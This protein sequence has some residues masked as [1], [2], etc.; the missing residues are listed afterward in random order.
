MQD[1]H[2]Y[3]YESLSCSTGIFTAWILSWHCIHSTG[4]AYTL[5]INFALLENCHLY[6]HNYIYRIYSSSNIITD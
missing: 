1:C 3:G 2:N 4:F 5:N 6:I